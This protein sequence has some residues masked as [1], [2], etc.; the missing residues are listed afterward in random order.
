MNN[1]RYI[2]DKYYKHINV[3]PKQEGH[4]QHYEGVADKI[5]EPDRYI[6]IYID[7]EIDHERLY[8]II[9]KMLPYT[10]LFLNEINTNTVNDMFDNFE[11]KEN[12]KGISVV[13]II[14]AGFIVT[15]LG[16]NEYK[17]YR[18]FDMREYDML[19]QQY[20]VCGMAKNEKDYIKDWVAYYIHLGF[21]KIYLFDNNDINGESY[22]DL[23]KEY[24]DN[25]QLEIIDIRGKT[26][27]QTAAYHILYHTVPF[28][29]MAIVDIDE[30]IWIKETS[31]YS[32]IK[33]YIDD[34]LENRPQYGIMLQW[35]CYRGTGMNADMSKPIWEIDTEPIDFS[36]R[37]NGRCEL[38]N[39][40]LKS[41]FKSDFPLVFNEHFGWIPES[42]HYKYHMDMVDWKGVPTYKIFCD[43]NVDEQNNAEVFVKHFI[44]R[45]IKNVFYNKY[46]RGHA[47]FDG[48]KGID[49][50]NFNQWL[51]NMN[52]YTDLVPYISKEEQL[53]MRSKGMKINYT[54]HPDVIL[55]NNILQ[56]NTNIN[57]CINGLS[58]GIQNWANV[59]YTEV[60]CSSVDNIVQPDYKDELGV[61]YNYNYD[62]NK[63]SSYNTYYCGY[64]IGE[65]KYMADNKYQEQIVVILGF[66]IEYMIGEVDKEHQRV[67]VNDLKNFLCYSNVRFMFREVL[68]HPDI[69]FIHNHFIKPIGDA[70]GWKDSLDEFLSKNS[71]ELPQYQLWNNTYVT[72]LSNYKKIKEFQKKFI[73]YYDTLDNWYIISNMKSGLSTPYQALICSI[74]API[75]NII[76]LYFPDL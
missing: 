15:P 29:Y 59:Q 41:I 7:G 54:F 18:I 64:Y 10:H 48:S 27:F 42:K 39:G 69:L 45:N 24:I 76:P 19:K 73:A 8:D 33:Q 40:W 65:E 56:G 47:G 5:D 21:D 51:Q 12:L 11:Q 43:F 30:F 67:Y 25:K 36:M 66:P 44:F 60:D 9:S 1:I 3:I 28:R 72:S 70:Y 58:A 63:Y 50:W 74:L 49:G 2:Y 75:S 23:L 34:T 46:L 62:F 4:M 35:R 20:A 22:N 17:D 32:N 68:E 14:G 16:D 26:S 55:I 52:Y 13:R 37:R 31:R 38:V 61:Q 6:S 71:L 57:A 53:F